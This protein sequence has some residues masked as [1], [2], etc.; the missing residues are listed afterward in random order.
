MILTADY[1]THTPYSHGKNTVDE[2]VCRAKELGL[3]EIGITDHGFS[4]VAFGLR[5]KEVAAYKAECRA[6]EEKYG[7]KVLVGIEANIRGVGGESDLREEDY[8]DFDLYLCGNHACIHFSSLRDN[9][10][11]GWRNLFLNNVIRKTTKRQIACN[12]KAYVNAIK[13]NPIDAITHLN[14][15]CPANALEVA[16]CAADYG[17]YIELDAKKAHL[18]DEELVEIAQKTSARFIVNSDAHWV[19]RIGD[20]ALI[21]EQLKRIDFPMERIDNIDGRLP[22]FRFAA[23]KKERGL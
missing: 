23:F 9:I 5:R 8:Q 17:T 15:Q 18:T 16:K 3:K 7:I 6:A 12:T 1:H 11:Y 10:G 20:T 22:N 4:H 19:E 13:N 2:N 14:Y 21:A